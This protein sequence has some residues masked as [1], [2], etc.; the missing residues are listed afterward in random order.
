MS[1]LDIL[2][3]K[4]IATSDE[5]GEQVG[6][7]SG[8]PIFGLDA[9]SSAAYGPEAALTLLIPLGLAGVAYIVPISAS[10]IA[11]L[12]IVY[13][14]YRQT[15]A[16]YPGG[17]GSYTVASE[18]LGTFPGL[19]AAAA[20]MLDYI[21]TAAVGIS[22]GVG[23][24]VSAVPNLEPH[25]LSLCLG[26][27]VLLTLVNLRGVREAGTVFIIPTYLFVCTLLLTIL[28]GVAKT[29]IAGGHPTP[30]VPP[31]PPV[32]TS[33]G[34]AGLWLLLQV[35][36]NGC[37]AMTGVEAVSNGVRAFREPTVKTAQRAL[38]V[39]I[40]LLVLLLAGIAY[41]VRT[42][43]IA[44]TD[45]GQPGYQSILSMLVAAV[46]GRGW[47]YYVTIGSVLLVLSLSA[48]TAFADF[49]RLCRTVA[50]NSYLPHAFGFRGRRL[51]YTEGILVL[52]ALTAVLLW[53][54][55]GVTD[56]LIPLYAIGAFLAFTLSQAGMVAHWRR[57]GGDG[58]GP[59][60]RASRHWW[61]WSPSLRRGHG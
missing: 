26:I 36:S 19:L 48:N 31:P 7:S 25:T 32:P 39:I 45:P 4:P 56:R 18:N 3:G 54:F 58:A 12:A 37:T 33:T 6:V 11:L 34:V 50:Q 55:G 61:Y 13:L 38:T 16:A 22:A 44:A 20:L 21:L 15:V 30:V 27:L 2:F 59:S 9:L 47:F 42:Y 49:P 41:L 43:G 57:V 1:I 46:A 52:A 14:S 53:L 23:A 24:L 35:F 40:A 10:I 8:I 17:G 60:R 51:V 29:V 5:R 28:V